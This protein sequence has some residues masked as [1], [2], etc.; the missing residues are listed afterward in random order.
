MIVEA[1]LADGERLQVGS[2]GLAEC[3]D[4]WSRGSRLRRAVSESCRRAAA[5]ASP[6][7]RTSAAR[8]CRSTGTRCRSRA[9]SSTWTAAGRSRSSAARPRS[10]RA[11]T[12]SWSPSWPRCSASIPSSSALRHRRHRHHAGRPRLLLVPRHVMTGNAAIQA[13]E[14]A[15]RRCWSRR[16]PRS[17]R[18][19]PE[20]SCLRDGRVFARDDPK[21]ADLRRGRRARRRASS[22]RSARSAPTRR[23]ARRGATRARA[24]VRRPRT[25]YSACVVEVG[26][27][28]ADRLDHRAEDLDR[29]RHRPRHQPGAR[30]GQVEGSVYMGLGEA[31]MEEQVFRRLPPKLSHALVHKIPSLLEYKSPTTLDMPEIDTI[32]V[33]TRDPTA[34]SAPRRSARGRCCRSSRR[35]PTPSTTRSAC[36]STRCRSRRRRF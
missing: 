20:R 24:S 9:C 31:L 3:I 25:R 34:R 32:L 5:S 12:T 33:E 27:R 23:R 22:A 4:T 35:W 36:A 14:Q 21:G 17:S 18:S 15:A 28:P 26:G 11:P 2:I 8:A 16:P 10:A 30:R 13:A 29:A 6:A 7:A 19:P 1:R